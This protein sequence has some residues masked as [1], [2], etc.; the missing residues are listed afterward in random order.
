[1]QEDSAG[2]DAEAAAEAAAAM[3]A[4]GAEGGGAT[5]AG[6]PE[7]TPPLATMFKCQKCPWIR[8]S[9]RQFSHILLIGGVS[10]DLIKAGY[11]RSRSVTE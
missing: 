4:Q 9:Q 1:M 10:L 3:G 2:G 5:G 7:A 11:P 6:A 8:K